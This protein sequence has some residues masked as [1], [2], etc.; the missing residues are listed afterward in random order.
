MCDV[1]R[2]THEALRLV[3][4]SGVEAPSD[5]VLYL[6]AAAGDEA[7][8]RDLVRRY[9]PAIRRFCAVLIG[10]AGAARDAAQEVFLS[11]WDM[12]RRY[13]PEAKLRQLL[14]VIARNRC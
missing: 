3:V 4:T 1:E 13:R 5:E 11:L 9:E 7:S 6:R 2:D 12:R 10:D 14:F 8:F